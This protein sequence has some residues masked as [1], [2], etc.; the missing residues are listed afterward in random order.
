MIISSLTFNFSRVSTPCSNLLISSEIFPIFSFKSLAIFSTA[1]LASK[2]TLPFLAVSEF[3]YFSDKAFGHLGYT[4]T[5]FWIDPE[6][7]LIVVLLTNRVH[8]T[9]EKP[10][11]KQVRR[12]FHNTVVKSILNFN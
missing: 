2:S 9:R 10:G 8:P 3:K 12:R 11:I 4:G 7:Q 1:L 5:S 6:Q